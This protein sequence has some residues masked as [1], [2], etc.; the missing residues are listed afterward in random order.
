MAIAFRVL[1]SIHATMLMSFTIIAIT[2][3]DV[4]VLPYFHLAYVVL[5]YVVPRHPLGRWAE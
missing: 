3:F 2:H 1:I 4:M 5:V